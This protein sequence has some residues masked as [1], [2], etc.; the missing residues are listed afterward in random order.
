MLIAELIEAGEEFFGA[1]ALGRF[2]HLLW[3]SLFLDHAV[4]HEDDLISHLTRKAD[5]VGNDDH[6]AVC[7]F[8]SPDNVEHLARQLGVE[9]GGRL[10]EAENVGL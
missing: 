10:V 9:R 5:L 4:V 7:A 8:Q 6:S 2:D 1:T 3:R